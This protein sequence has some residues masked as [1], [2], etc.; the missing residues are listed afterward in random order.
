MKRLYPKVAVLILK[1]SVKEKKQGTPRRRA[2]ESLTADASTEV[3]RIADHTEYLLDM[4]LGLLSQLMWLDS[5]S[6]NTARN[7]NNSCVQNT[8][9]M[10]LNTLHL[11][12]TTKQEI[13]IM[14]QFEMTHIVVFE[15][16]NSEPK[17][18]PI[19]KTFIS[20]LTNEEAYTLTRFRKDQLPTLLC[21]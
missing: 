5:H 12:E 11:L 4:R 6:H 10:K 8:R 20:Q 13:D 16:P 17:N 14:S 1:H 3:Q 2:V 19:Q 9:R 15:D 18:F 21:H 7:N